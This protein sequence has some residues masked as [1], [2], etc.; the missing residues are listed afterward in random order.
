ME[1]FFLEK[2]NV[3]FNS[4]LLKYS[5]PHKSSLSRVVYPVEVSLTLGLND[6]LAVSR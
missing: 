3:Y 2:E 4:C 6:K 5:F 1:G